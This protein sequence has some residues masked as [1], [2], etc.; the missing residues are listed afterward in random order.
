MRMTRKGFFVVVAITVTT[1]L[2]GTAYGD[3]RREPDTRRQGVIEIGEPSPIS[4]PALQR[5]A[6]AISQLQE[7]LDQYGY[8]EYAETQAI[9]PQWPWESHEVRLFYLR[10]DVETIFGH[11]F[12]SE[13]APNF[14]VL[15][16]QDNIAPEKR[17]QIDAVLQARSAPSAPAGPSSAADMS[18]PA[19]SA[20]APATQPD[21]GQQSSGAPAT[22]EGLVARIEAAA[23][24]AA[25]AADH[26]AEASDAAVRAADRTVSIVEKMEHSRRSSARPR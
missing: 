16:F 26:A 19:P 1:T 5:E 17:H 12:L 3:V 25:A 13:A 14:G 7:Y 2:T 21:S 18:A 24:R 20:P 22:Q 4:I 8:P 11:V 9:G 23:D 15:K 6:A 10:R